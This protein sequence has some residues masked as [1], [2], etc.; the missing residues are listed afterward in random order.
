MA[1][2]R[3]IQPKRT[4]VIN[5]IFGKTKDPEYDRTPGPKGYA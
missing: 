3:D 4:N 5:A 1:Y 2:E